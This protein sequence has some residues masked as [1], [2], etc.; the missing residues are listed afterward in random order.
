MND[1]TGFRMHNTLSCRDQLSRQVPTLDL[2]PGV[3]PRLP[4][5]KLTIVVHALQT[6]SSSSLRVGGKSSHLR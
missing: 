1:L 3:L 4:F 6:R 2:F 5:C